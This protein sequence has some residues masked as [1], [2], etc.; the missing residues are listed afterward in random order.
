MKGVIFL[1]SNVFLLAACQK[2]DTSLQEEGITLQEAQLLV[3]AQSKGQ[4]Q[5]QQPFT[6]QWETFT[7]QGFN[8]EQ[9]PFASVKIV[10]E[11]YPTLD[12]QFFIT[13]TAKGLE[14]KIGISF[15]KS[16]FSTESAITGETI[17]DNLSSYTARE[18][19]F[20]ILDEYPELRPYKRKLKDIYNKFLSNN[21]DKCKI[22]RNCLFNWMDMQQV[23]N[24]LERRSSKGNNFFPSL[25]DECN[26]F[27]QVVV[28]LTE[29]VVVGERKK[30]EEY[31]TISTYIPPFEWDRIK[32]LWEIPEVRR[33]IREFNSEE[34]GGGGG[35]N[36]EVDK[37]NMEE[38]IN[39]DKTVPSCVINI[40]NDLK[41][42]NRNGIPI[43]YTEVNNALGKY[44]VEMFENSPDIHILYVVEN[45]GYG[46]YNAQTGTL[47]KGEK[48]LT[49]ISHEMLENAS[50]LFIAKT[51]IHEML[52]AYFK[53]IIQRNDLPQGETNDFISDFNK[54]IKSPGVNPYEGEHEMMKNYIDV[55]AASLA[56]YDKNKCPMEYYRRLSWTGLEKT[57]D[58]K[59][60]PYEERKEIEKVLENERYNN[61][62]NCS[63]KSAINGM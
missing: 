38:L 37:D 56:E 45:M 15:P 11:K 39:Y 52:H 53:S 17:K 19:G 21:C 4:N 5:F 46:Y 29:V 55:M 36:N 59:N 50:E 32:L 12:T 43:P 13:Q 14:G 25:C 63:S 47:R 27:S 16:S 51:L 62:N 2:E 54:V 44:L 34:R 28:S 31:F 24:R 22:C 1:I 30:R 10:F 23:A 6:V 42:L 35:S 7:Q 8:K 9:Q 40:I 26:R 18:G 33:A 58:F 3:N 57:K 48:Y 61:P 60:I 49:R 20:P 41:L